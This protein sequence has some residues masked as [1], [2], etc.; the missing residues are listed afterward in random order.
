[1]IGLPS[2][3]RGIVDRGLPIVDDRRTCGIDAD[4]KQPSNTQGA[5]GFNGDRRLRKAS[6]LYL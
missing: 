2:G 5:K 1:L 6:T 4:D 3:E